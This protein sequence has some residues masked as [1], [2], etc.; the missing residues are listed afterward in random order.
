MSQSPVLPASTTLPAASKT[1]RCSGTPRRRAS[2]FA[3]STETPV[4]SGVPRAARTAFPTLMAARNVPLGARSETASFGG[5][6]AHPA[7]RKRNAMT[8]AARMSPPDVF[9]FFEVRRGVDDHHAH[10]VRGGL[11]TMRRIGGKKARVARAHGELLAGH[12]HRGGA[13]EQVADLLD[14]RM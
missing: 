9:G 13:F 8:T 11:E 3:R 7:I 5:V 6:D 10:L 2:S 12:F 14:A 1:M 4:G